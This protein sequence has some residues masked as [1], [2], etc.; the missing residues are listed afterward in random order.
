[1]RPTLSRGSSGA[2]VAT[3]QLVIG[4]KPDGDFGPT[5]ERL[6]KEWQAARGIEADG[7]VG[8]ITWAVTGPQSSIPF[9]QAKNCG[10]TVSGRKIDLLVIHTMETPDRSGAARWCASFFGVPDAPLASAHFCVDSQETIQ[11][12]REDVVAWAAPGANRHGIHIE[13][14]GYAKQTTEQW[15]DEYSRAVLAR[16]AKLA[17]D[18]CKRHGIPTVK[19]SP[20]DLVKG[21]RGICGHVDVT[22]AFP[23]KGRTH[24]DPGPAFPWT[25]YLELVRAGGD[26]EEPMP[27]THRN[28]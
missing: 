26:N 12:V 18:I 25:R 2:D 6:T 27:E 9:V 8:P 24:W 21:R 16:S 5:T 3:W 20:E 11:C 28:S 22:N 17:A 7:V 19:L 14:A 4:A 15:D 23:G 13:H 1:M 10:P